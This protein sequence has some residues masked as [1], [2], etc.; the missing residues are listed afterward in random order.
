MIGLFFKTNPFVPQVL[1]IP[2]ILWTN[3][4]PAFFV[5]VWFQIEPEKY[6]Y[7]HIAKVF[8]LMTPIIPLEDT[9]VA[10]CQLHLL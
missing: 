8:Q 5:N 10:L 4:Q 1:V 2:I 6:I 7:N 3:L 9:I